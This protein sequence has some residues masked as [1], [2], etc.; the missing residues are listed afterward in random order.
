MKTERWGNGGAVEIQRLTAS[1]LLPQLS[2]DAFSLR[3]RYAET[4]RK[5]MPLLQMS[6]VVC[7]SAL[8]AGGVGG[9][10]RVLD[11][12]TGLGFLI[13]VDDW[14]FKCSLPLPLS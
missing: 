4:P 3:V 8:K 5:W 9:W 12:V 2:Q 1:K 13:L 14:R 10:R 6:P 11:F 7:R